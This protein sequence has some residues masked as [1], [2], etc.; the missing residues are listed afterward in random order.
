MSYRMV[1]RRWRGVGGLG[2]TSTTTKPSSSGG[3]QTAQDVL[4]AVT[5]AASL[6]P[7]II[8]ATQGGGATSTSLTTTGITT[9]PTTTVPPAASAAPSWYWPV[10]IGTGLVMLGGVAFVLTSAHKK[11]ATAVAKN[12]RRHMRRNSRRHSGHERVYYVFRYWPGAGS[13]YAHRSVISASATKD[14]IHPSASGLRVVRARSQA[15]AIARYR[16]GEGIAQNR[17][18][19]R[20]SRNRLS[21][22]ERAK[23]PASKFVFPERRAWPLD[24]P[25][26][27]YDAMR[28]MHL[29]RVRS[30]SDYLKIS[31]AIQRRYPGVWKQYKHMLSWPRTSA[32]KRKGIATRRRRYPHGTRYASRYAANRRRHHRRVSRNRLSA[33]ERERIPARDFVFPERRAWPLDTPERAY[34]AMQALHMGRVRS[35]GDY[36]KISNAIQRRYPGVWR[37]YRGLVSWPKAEAARRRRAVS[38]RKHR[39]TSRAA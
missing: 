6:V 4:Q 3:D 9:T 22:R 7:S 16:R 26:R 27:A 32:A 31:N 18:G 37:Q 36:L 39:R 19:R 14:F 8:S 2:Q 11:P 33:R 28:A 34:E 25:K 15:A 17:R 24:T 38:R 10:I 35:A 23:I 12:R 1:D 30:A 13:P 29:G 20:I 5:A 21:A